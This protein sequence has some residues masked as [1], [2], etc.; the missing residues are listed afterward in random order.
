V[1]EKS[2]YFS[3]ACLINIGG[4]VVSICDICVVLVAKGGVLSNSL[5]ET[6]VGVEWISVW[7]ELIEL[8]FSDKVFYS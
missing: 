3:S 2:S 4:V 6:I 1:S 8:S 7:E 5:E